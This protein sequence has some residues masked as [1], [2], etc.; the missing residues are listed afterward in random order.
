MTDSI[1]AKRRRG[2][3][4]GNQNAKG[5]RGNPSPRRNLGNRGGI[6]ASIGNQN[7]RKR[8]RG[9]AALL[10]E[11]RNDREAREWLEANQSAL[12]S[13]P[14][15]EVGTDAVD[16][17]MHLCLTPEDIAGR[18]REFEFG[19]FIKPEQESERRLAA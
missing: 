4:P 19:L 8:P 6:G 3:Q 11:Y 7:A 13:L 17:A 14:E 18:G 12:A 1:P 9:V 16:I 10:L 15:S 5:N 2:A